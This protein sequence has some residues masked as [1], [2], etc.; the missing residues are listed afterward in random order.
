MAAN[1]TV[2]T[3]VGAR[4]INDVE[5]AE[6]DEGALILSDAGGGILAVFAIGAWTSAVRV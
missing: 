1:L 4:I 3:P 6:V 5:V 2:L